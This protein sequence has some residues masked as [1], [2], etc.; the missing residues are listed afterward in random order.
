MIEDFYALSPYAL[1]KDK[2]EQ[3]LT[4]ELKALTKYHYAH[5]QYYRNYLDALGFDI[6]KMQ[7][8]ESLPFYP[9]RLFKQLDLMSIPKEKVFKTM[10]SS[11]TT[12][13]AVSKI[14]IDQEN[15]LM[16]QK[17]LIKILNDYVGNKRLPMLII[18]SPK[19]VKDRKLFSARGAAVMGLNVMA[20]QMVFALDEHMTLN[21]QVL[22]EFMQK[23][24]DKPFMIF[25]FTF[26]IW[27]HL[28]ETLKKKNKKYDMSNAYL[29]QGGGWKKLDA[30]AVS[31]ETFK[32]TVHELCGISHFIDHYGMVEQTGCIYAECEYGHYHASIYSDVIVRNI[33]DF[34]PCKIGEK[35]I[36]EVVSVL[37]HAY[38]GH[39]LLTEDEGVILGED[40]CPCGRKGKYIKVLGRMK[41]AEIRGCSDT[42]AA[43]F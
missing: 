20:R 18:D 43:Q 27:Q 5:C 19:V 42:Y 35:G 25:G 34:S 15:A 16:Q 36:I 37:P 30:L 7:S 40:D 31:R 8:Y 29:F 23:Y 39:A 14:Y 13:Q 1:E 38:P 21:E 4:K 26:M 12:G 41:N 9:V 28:V 11:G 2:K 6:D 10:T 22:D 17:V 32:K 33:E 24:G 3:M